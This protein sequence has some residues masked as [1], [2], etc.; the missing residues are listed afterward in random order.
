[1][2]PLCLLPCILSRTIVHSG[3]LIRCNSYFIPIYAI[4]YP[5]LG[6]GLGV[7]SGTF[8]PRLRRQ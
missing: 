2:P 8:E 4:L 5:R 3:E 6:L 7:H 1:V